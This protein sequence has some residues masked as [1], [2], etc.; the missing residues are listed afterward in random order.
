MNRIVSVGADSDGRRYVSIE[1][2][3][4][5]AE[6]VLR[7]LGL[8]ES[9][10]KPLTTPG[11]KVDEKEVALREKKRFRWILKMLRGTGVVS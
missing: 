4:R 2:D 3:I 11:Y 7:N 10:A 6:L 1:P 9:K 8:E 5:H